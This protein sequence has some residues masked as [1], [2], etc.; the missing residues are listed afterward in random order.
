[1]VVIPDWTALVEP[2]FVFFE[3]EFGLFQIGSGY[4]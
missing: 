1:L 3:F 4:K 2:V